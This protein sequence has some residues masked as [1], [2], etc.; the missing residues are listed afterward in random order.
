MASLTVRDLPEE[1]M[2]TL[3]IRAVRNHRSLNGEILHIFATVAA[4]GD[5]F[6][7][8][9]RPGPASSECSQRDAVIALAGKWEDDRSLEE[10]IADI[11]S[12]RT[13]G[14]EVAL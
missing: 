13:P 12:A 10:T 4:F 5:A 9:V 14:R 2:S 8:P 11:E 6:V 3:R 7:F 1:T